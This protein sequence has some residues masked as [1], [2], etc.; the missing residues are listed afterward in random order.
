HTSQTLNAGETATDNAK[1]IVGKH[2]DLLAEL[3]Q[4]INA[5]HLAMG[6][7]GA[8]RGEPG[9]LTDAVTSFTVSDFAR[10]FPSNGSGSDHGWGGHHLVV[11]GAVK[12]G[13][14]YGQFP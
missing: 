2:A 14:T 8:S 12:G 11:G 6:D 9:S 3:S 4:S 5:L 1:V 10:T 7:I 13:A